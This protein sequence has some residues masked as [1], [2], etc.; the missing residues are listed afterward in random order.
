MT[1]SFKDLT[2]AQQEEYRR[3]IVKLYGFEWECYWRYVSEDTI[4]IYSEMVNFEAP[5]IISDKSLVAE[6]DKTCKAWQRYLF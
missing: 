5:A 4:E 6:W 2:P 1:I 3:G